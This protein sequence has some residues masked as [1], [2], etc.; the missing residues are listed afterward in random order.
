MAEIEYTNDF[1]RVLNESA[2]L[3]RQNRPKEAAAL[4]QPLYKEAPTQPDLAIN[5]G[6][7]YIMQRKWSRAVDVLSKAVEANPQNIM[8]WT[9]L[10]AAHLGN[11]E[12]AGPKHQA[13]AIA[14]YERV[15]AL[16][17]MAP[18]VHYHLGL[19]YK[20]QGNLETAS[21]FFQQ[22]LEVNPADRDAR[23]WLEQMAL[24]GLAS[25]E[26]QQ[27]SNAKGAV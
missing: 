27:Q 6:S 12:T 5:L 20:E 14:A 1:R 24:Q 11:L 26:A 21:L 9:N 22:A 10:A 7:A 8:L 4:L 15:L 25:A 19:I 3:L 2:R 23:Y 16:D 13:R 18:N 17:P